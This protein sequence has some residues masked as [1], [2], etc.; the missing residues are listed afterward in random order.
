[1]KKLFIIAMSAVVFTACN[2]STTHK[3]E[4]S[5][6]TPDSKEVV[7]MQPGYTAEEGDVTYRDNKLMVWKSG[8]WVEADNDIELDNGVKVYR[9]GEVKRNNEVVVLHDGEVVTKMGKFF[10]KA[11]EGIEDAWDATKKGVRTAGEKVKEGAEKVND[12]IQGKDN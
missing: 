1:M 7:V 6:E 3:D 4:V 9:N 5:V 2:D 8:A 11:G 10:N 12:K